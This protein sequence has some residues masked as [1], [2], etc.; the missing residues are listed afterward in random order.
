MTT[1]NK[2]SNLISS[3]AP[4]YVRNDHTKFIRFLELYYEYLEQSG[5][6]VSEIKNIQSYSDIDQTIDPYAQEFYDQF[7]KL[8]PTNV[9]NRNY[10][11]PINADK[12]LIIKHVKDFYRARGTEKSVKF[13]LRILFGEE[14]T[15]YYPKVDVLKASDGKWSIEKSIKVRDVKVNGAITENIN[16]ILKFASKNILGNTSNARAIVETVD[17]FYEKGS[18]VYELKISNQL[19][20]FESSESIFTTF[21][22]DGSIK[23]LTANLYS[24]IVASVTLLSGG[25]GYVP[26]NSV[27]VESNT[28]SNASVII[29]NVT[30]GNIKVILVNSGGAG[31][32]NGNSILITGGG[33]SGATGNVA[34]SAD[35]SVHPNSYNIVSSTISL[36]SDIQIGNISYPNLNMS[37]A[38][39]T[40]INA[41]NSYT[42]SNCG[43]ISRAVLISPGNNYITIPTFDVQSNTQIRALGILGRMEINNP[44]SGY[45][46]GDTI[47]FTNV[48]GGYGTGAVANVSNVNGN[49]AITQVSFVPLPG[50]TTGGSGYEQG[51]LPAAAVASNTGN[52]A[53]ISVTAILGDGENLNATV[54]SIGRILSLRIVSGGSD[55][56]TAPVIN[57]RSQGDGTA[58]AVSTIITGTFTFP[59][60][61]INDDGHLSGFNFLEDRDYYQNYSY[62]VRIGQSLKSYKKA[63]LDLIHPG[64]MKLF[65]EFMIRDENIASTI[66]T[67]STDN[68]K[69]LKFRTA[70]FNSLGSANGSNI[71][72]NLTNHGAEA[73]DNVYIEYLTTSSRNI[74]F[75]NIANAGINY[76]NGYINFESASGTG[77]N[78]QIVVNSIGSIVSVVLNNRGINYNSTDTVFA[79]VANLL[80][81]NIAT[82]SIANTGSGYGNGF[83]TITGGSGKNA[84]ANVSVNATGAI[85]SVTINNRGTGY[86]DGQANNISMNVES[87]LSYNVSN[88]VIING[89]TGFSNGF[90]RFVG[91]SGYGA[92][93]NVSVNA[94][95]A[96]TSVTINNRGNGYN[97]TDLNEL[98]ANVSHLIS[99]NISN[100]FLIAT[101]TNFSNGYISIEGGSGSGANAEISVNRSGVITQ[102]TLNSGGTGYSNGDAVIA[103]VASLV[104]YNIASVNI[105]NAGIDYSNG[106]ITFE[107]GA[108]RDANAII[109]V[110]GNGAIKTV[111]LVSGGSGYNFGDVVVANVANLLTYNIASANV[112]V[113]GN[114]YSNGYIII[115]GGS[116]RDANASLT[117]NYTTGVIESVT[118]NA[119]GTGYAANDIVIG[120]ANELLTTN[121]LSL[122]IVSAGAGY[123]NGFII[124]ETS[125][126]GHDANAEISVNATGSIVSTNLISGGTGYRAI[127]TIF[128]NTQHLGSSNGNV[129]VTLSPYVNDA[130]IRFVLQAGGNAANLPVNLVRGNANSATLNVNLRFIGSSANIELDLQKGFGGANLTQTLQLGGNQ[131]NLSVSLQNEPITAVKDGIYR[132]VAANTNSLFIS[133]SNTTNTFGTASVGISV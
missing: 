54:D 14:A 104:K 64:G 112:I 27:P 100:I 128:A 97:L 43:P 35:G 3:Q 75:V 31:F 17:V 37:N 103:N 8:I 82:I 122:G 25:L 58:Q 92:N 29:S 133:Q 86:L 21:E 117:A 91:G 119:P 120:I 90:I 42:F 118:I 73:N 39:T 7:L 66:D 83:V 105:A 88:A 108:G 22:E 107:G 87:L 36:V 65:G 34:V 89:G 63:I 49:G 96:I 53:S 78:A 26:G 126:I 98:E 33:G 130:N 115:S 11:A 28:G 48:P 50:H 102:I 45:V 131:A 71:V 19:R 62:V 2:I 84:N 101:G 57:L 13:L 74:G 40:I 38:N 93:A 46:I 99:Y 20:S 6:V 79:N 56:E 72:F 124:F 44:G 51:A 32:Q 109:S 70:S 30:R 123:S 106:Y 60:R 41:V 116:G 94:T 10:T 15:L 77:A 9:Q 121:I 1:N 55:Y 129:S 59:G 110:Y 52:G 61:Y 111:N 4:F 113:S 18:P 76:S 5:K 114:N 23:T 95:G 69:V 80:T 125:G 67:V 85:T 132:V 24:G 16:D 81:Y 47:S 127:D 68:V 12:A